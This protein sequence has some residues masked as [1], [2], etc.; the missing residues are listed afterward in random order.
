VAERY[1]QVPVSLIERVAAKIRVAEEPCWIWLGQH[2]EKGYGIV[3][4][5]GRMQRAHR[6]VYEQIVGPIPDNMLLDHTCFNKACVNPH[7]LRPVS[8]KENGEHRRGAQVN[9]SSGVRG[10]SWHKATQK[11]AAKVCHNGRGIQRGTV[12]TRS[13]R[14]N[15]P[16][17]LYGQ[18]CSH[19]T[20]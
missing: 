5:N 2:T 11:W 20:T 4:M 16:S 19:T 17:T 14:R 10:V 9:S 7:H 15:V 8:T 6:V 12:R 3:H 13:R 1:V 18:S